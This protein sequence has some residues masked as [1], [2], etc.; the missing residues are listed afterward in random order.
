MADGGDEQLLATSAGNRS[1]KLPRST[2][3]P[4]PRAGYGPVARV[5]GH[6]VHE[7]YAADQ[8][9]QRQRLRESTVQ[10]HLPQSLEP[11]GIDLPAGVDEETTSMCRA[12]R[13]VLHVLV[14]LND[15]PGPWLCDGQCAR[16]HHIGIATHSLEDFGVLEGSGRPPT[17][18]TMIIIG[19]KLPDREGSVCVEGGEPFRFVLDCASLRAG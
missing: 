6:D 16:F 9:P 17:A 2:K 14:S 19:L 5:A 15:R 18:L 3:L 8:T 12:P 7:L 11:T 13:P 10:T 4:V 1:E